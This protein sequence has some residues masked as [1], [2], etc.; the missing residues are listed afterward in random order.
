MCTVVVMAWAG[1]GMARQWE[2]GKIMETAP[3]LSDCRGRG[4][5]GVGTQ[6]ATHPPTHSWCKWGSRGSKG[7]LGGQI[8]EAYTHRP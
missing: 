7:V 6:P 1:V 3:L 2:E 4:R 8:T 5:G